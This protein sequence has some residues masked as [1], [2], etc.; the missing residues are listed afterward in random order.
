MYIIAQ[1]GRPGSLTI[2]GEGS[3]GRA[4]RISMNDIDVKFCN[5]DIDT[6]GETSSISLLSSIR[7]KVMGK[8]QNSHISIDP[9]SD[10]LST[11]AYG[12][13][14][15]K[16]IQ[17]AQ[18]FLLLFSRAGFLVVWKLFLCLFQHFEF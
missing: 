1:I 4:Q 15:V 12:E 14:V 8:E 10:M 3:G 17:A 13:A 18:Y 9:R 2:T 6:R 11:T 5:M 7:H 16:Y